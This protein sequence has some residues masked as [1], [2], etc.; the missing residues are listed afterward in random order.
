MGNLLFI[1][2]NSA[3][4]DTKCYWEQEPHHMIVI[5]PTSTILHPC[6]DSTVTK[7]VLY[8]TK[9]VYNLITGT[10]KT[11]NMTNMYH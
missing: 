8:I 5:V 10:K 11:I 3:E 9:S 2:H 6:L 4:W 1:K 7:D